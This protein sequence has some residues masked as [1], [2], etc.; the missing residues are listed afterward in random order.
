MNKFPEL[1]NLPLAKYVDKAMDWLL[2]NLEGFFDFIGFIIL[3]V[4]LAFE[5]VFLFVPWFVIILLVGY[6]GWKLVGSL[7]TGILF[8][9]T[10]QK[11][12]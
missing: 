11:I 3:K 8:I 7:K 9:R 2:I 5:D 1:W 4:V 12:R 10:S 6:A